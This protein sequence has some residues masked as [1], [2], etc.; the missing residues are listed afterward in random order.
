[1]V[2]VESAETWINPSQGVTCT[3]LQEF[4]VAGAVA[5]ADG[6]RQDPPLEAFEAEIAR[7]K[8]IQDQIQVG[9]FKICRSASKHDQTGC[10]LVVPV[11]AEHGT[12]FH[13]EPYHVSKR[14]TCFMLSP[15]VSL[16][17]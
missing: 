1:M 2:V 3:G 8:G 17:M 15:F 12:A 9:N 5:Q 7:F 6:T 10:L 13:S 4:L 14:S 11:V 16:R